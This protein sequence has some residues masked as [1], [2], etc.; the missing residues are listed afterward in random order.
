M[1]ELIRMNQI[2]GTITEGQARKMLAILNE[3]EVV[4]E[5]SDS[6]IEGDFNAMDFPGPSKKEAIA[7]LKTPEGMKAIQI[8][9]NV[10]NA[11]EFDYQDLIKAIKKSRFPKMN[12]FRAAA[13]KAGLE[14]DNL[15]MDNEGNGD[16]SVENPNYTSRGAAI[17]FFGDKV[18]DY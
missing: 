12:H 6:K 11:Q 3:N 13:A 10:V 5:R 1:K 18:F 15:G 16:F 2:A 9:K 14:L 7:Y 4:K 17:T 8:L